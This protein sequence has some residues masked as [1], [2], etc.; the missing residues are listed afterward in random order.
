[1]K[2]VEKVEKW[3]DKD[4]HEVHDIAQAARIIVTEYG[5]DGRVVRERIYFARE[6]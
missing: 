5:K 2:A 4:G 1:M 6:D 3:F